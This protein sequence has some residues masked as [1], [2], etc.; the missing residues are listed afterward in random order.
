MVPGIDVP[1]PRER[2][3]VVM[4]QQESLAFGGVPTLCTERQLGFNAVQSPLNPA[5]PGVSAHLPDHWFINFQSSGVER[6][7][8]TPPP[9]TEE[10]YAPLECP[11]QDR[12]RTSSTESD[13]DQP[14]TPNMASPEN[15]RPIYRTSQGSDKAKA[16]CK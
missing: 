15:P 5:I 16:A 3:R 12:Q 2:P 14:E 9:R 8:E 6:T 1:P 7:E 13:S 11:S 4:Y 10:Y